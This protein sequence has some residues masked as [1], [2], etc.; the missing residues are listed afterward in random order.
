MGINTS[1]AK[2]LVRARLHGA[3]FANT[4]TIGR[5]S[6]AIPK[7][8]V[9]AIARKL[10]V[11][12]LD[13]SS[14]AAN[15]FADDFFRTLLGAE[16]LQ[17]IDYSDYEK[18]DIVHDLN[19]PIAEDLHGRFDALVDGG[20]LEHIFDVKQVLTN[21]MNMVKVGGGVFVATAANNLC[22]HGFYQF[23]PEFFYR[24]FGPAN[25]FIVNDM[26]LIECPLLS[27]ETSRHQRCFRVI[28]PATIGR[29]IDLIT[30]KPVLIFVH[31]TR[32]ANAVPFREIPLQSDYR[33][34]WQ[35]A[36]PAEAGDQVAKPFEYLTALEELRGRL[37]EARESSLANDRFF[38]PLKR[39]I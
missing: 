18:V 25:G 29:R 35:S 20:S 13:W 32:I 27:V 23:S 33:D 36:D 1:I 37:R 16:T 22:G 8:D 21:Y 7:K 4:V 11:R 38:E 12:G 14:F 3:S 2:L 26:V 15:A 9:K 5:Q 31:A 19:T 34:K 10:G 28:D 17:S 24:V 6:L 39:V 30:R